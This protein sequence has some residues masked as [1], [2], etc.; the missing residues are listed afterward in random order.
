MRKAACRRAEG[1]MHPSKSHHIMMIIE[2]TD[3]GWIYKILYD[4]TL[5]RKCELSLALAR[6]KKIRLKKDRVMNSSE[7]RNYY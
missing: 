7:H 4:E 3:R 2:T 6:G 1:C 5:M